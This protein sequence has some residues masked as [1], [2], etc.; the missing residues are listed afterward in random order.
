MQQLMPMIHTK[1][2]LKLIKRRVLARMKKTIPAAIIFSIRKQEK[3]LRTKQV[4]MT[5]KMCTPTIR[6][7]TRVNK[8]IRFKTTMKCAGCVAS[9]TPGLDALKEV[10]SWKA[11]VSG[12]EKTLQIEADE[13]A[14]PKVLFALEKAGFK[15]ERI[16]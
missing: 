5:I 7:E 13:S 15:A 8:T 14:I 12:A 11:D 1:A 4:A 6:E 9:V 3:V 16:S 10:T 2:P